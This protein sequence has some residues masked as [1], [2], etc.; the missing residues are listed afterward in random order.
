MD[1]FERTGR[2]LFSRRP[3]ASLPR[4][5]FLLVSGALAAIV[6][7]A[8]GAA[9]AD[10]WWVD[11]G[12][13]PSSSH[14]TAFDQI[15]KSNVN[16][17]Q[18]A[19]FYPYGNV[20]FNPIVV[21]DV[22]Y[23]SGRNESLVA[24]D[25]TT[26]K[27]LWV[28]DGLTGLSV[29]GINFWRSKDGTDKRLIFNLGVFL[30]EIDAKTGKLI[31]TFGRDGAVDLREGLA[32]GEYGFRVPNPGRVFENSIILG[33]ATGEGWISPP[34][35]IRAYDVITGRRM[36]QFHT[37]PMPGEFGY[38]TYESKNAYKYVGGNNNWGEMSIDD[39]RGIVYL[40]TGSATYDF[41]GADRIGQDLY[42]NCLLALDARTGKRL[43]HFQTIHH[44]LWDLD[45][46]SAPQLVTVMHNGRKV[47]AVAHAGKTGFLYVFNRATGEALWP[48]EERSVPKSD[49]PG[50]F[51]WPTQPFPTK[52]PAFVRQYYG[53]DDVNPWLLA[54][55][56][57][58]TLRERVAKA[59]NGTGP[60]G[61]IFMPP[62]VN[63]DSISMP[64][65]QG[66]SNWGTTAADPD[67]GL[68]FVLGIDEVAILKLQNV[69]DTN[70][71][72]RG[73]GPGGPGAATYAQYCSACH[74]AN[75]QNPLPGVPSLVGVTNRVAE[76]VIR[77]NITNGSGNMRPV[78]GITDLEITAVI[79][80]LTTAG[81]AAGAG[82]G[83]G[84]GASGETFP[85]GPVVQTG[86][87]PVPTVPTRTG[88]PGFGGRGP[89]G[90]DVPYPEDAADAPKARYSTGYNVMGTSTRPPYSRLTAYDLNT[91]TIKWQVPVG[92]D[93]NTVS[94][95]GPTGTG[96][97]G[98]RT[99]I[100]PTKAGIVF[101]AGSDGK[102][103]GYDEEDGR[104]LWTGNLGGA[105]RGIPVI[106]QS[107][108]R[109]YLVVVAQQGGGRGGGGRAAAA[110]PTPVASDTPRGFIAFALPTK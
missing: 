99:G 34:G 26:G 39:Q 66:G 101:L 109:E 13:G 46:V 8:V 90:G 71:G 24:L 96:A 60:Q 110:P 7:A 5:R 77:T 28:H 42:A 73:G 54:A 38:D 37:T 33:M 85:P 78:P 25:A 62:A 95:G 22:M 12:G 23:V 50:E 58:A 49:V 103:R 83:R 108:G 27:E 20:G 86:G 17:L 106:Y 105:G 68:V 48:I 61:S 43:W 9:G 47:D 53:V 15:N 89:T 64:G 57:Q 51:A 81:R 76:D 80:Y 67:K 97:V 52:P 72:P 36:W 30:E 92:D 79:N 19:W 63:E 6:A 3:I 65:N 18:V 29:R 40:P 44:D 41:Y 2:S 10:G 88:G 32:R 93:P 74:G 35:D 75:M 59:R 4:L 56:E 87:A 84:R 107:K 102:V 1:V 100:M 82:A 70:L 45:N 31:P 14:F 69:M 16:Q 94:R 98:L 104:V 21:D 91:G 55:P 11:N